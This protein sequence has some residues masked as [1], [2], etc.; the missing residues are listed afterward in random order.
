MSLEPKS[1]SGAPADIPRIESP[2]NDDVA[3]LKEFTKPLL[4]KRGATLGIRHARFEKDD[5]VTRT[6]VEYAFDENEL[7][8][9]YS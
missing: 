2:S 7:N 8:P 3:D 6:V 9:N 4:G 1:F 5:G